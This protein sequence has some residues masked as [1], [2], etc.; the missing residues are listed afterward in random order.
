MCGQCVPE[1]IRATFFTPAPVPKK[2]TPAP[3][4]KLFGNLHSGSCLHSENLKAVYFAS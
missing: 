2:V 1:V 3:A 4:P